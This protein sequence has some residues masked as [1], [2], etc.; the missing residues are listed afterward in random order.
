[1]ALGLLTYVGAKGIAGKGREVSWIVWV[2][3]AVFL[4][5]YLLLPAD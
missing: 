3:A 1:M 4:L 2:L 5:R